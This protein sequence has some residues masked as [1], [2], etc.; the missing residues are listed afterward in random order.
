MILK[1]F[2]R[3][4]RQF[5][6]SKEETKDFQKRPKSLKDNHKI[7]KTVLTHLRNFKDCFVDYE[8]YS[9]IL[10]TSLKTVPEIQRRS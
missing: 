3:F 8:K 10:N 9:L 7:V 2:Q 6:K 5:Q 1:T 4:L